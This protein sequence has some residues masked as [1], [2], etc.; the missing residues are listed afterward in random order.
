MINVLIFGCGGYGKK[1]KYLLDE[2]EY[3]IIGFID[4]NKYIKNVNNSMN[5]IGKNVYLPT[6]IKDLDFDFIIL[7]I[8]DYYKEMENQLVEIL[9]ETVRNK[10]LKFYTDNKNIYY[11]D[12]RVAMLRNCADEIYRNKVQGAVAELGVYRG[13]FAKYI[14]RYFPEKKL[15]LFDTFEGFNE[16]DKSQKEEF[17]IVYRKSTFKDTNISCVMEKMKYKNNIILKK[18]YFPAT[19]EDLEEQFAFVSIDADLY[20]PIKSGLEYFYPRLNRGGYIFVHDFGGF[21]F[22]GCKK[23]VIEFCNENN[24]SYVPILD[25]TLSVIITK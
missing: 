18:G 11:L 22:I 10:I 16:K 25:R 3:N 17:G 6:E 1:V 2:D 24:I 14:N 23:A 5:E 7:P 20:E 9:G 12:E 13:D 8:I 4:N 15:Y 19:V 21:D